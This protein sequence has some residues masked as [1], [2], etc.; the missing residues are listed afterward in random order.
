MKKILLLTLAILFSSFAFAIEEVQRVR[1]KDAINIALENNV[2]LKSK[3]TTSPCL[4]IYF[5]TI[6]L[7]QHFHPKKN[8]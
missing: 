4:G 5:F 8:F 2:E 7:Y 1:L 6:F 3:K